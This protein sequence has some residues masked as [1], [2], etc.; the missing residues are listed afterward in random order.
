MAFPESGRTTFLPWLARYVATYDAKGKVVK[1]TK[2]KSWGL[3][4]LPDAQC[5]ARRCVK[6]TVTSK[7][8]AGGDISMPGRNFHGG[9]VLNV[10]MNGDG[11]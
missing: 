9:G 8:S 1:V 11:F 6:T 5:T 4:G 7:I 2:M 10:A 3:R